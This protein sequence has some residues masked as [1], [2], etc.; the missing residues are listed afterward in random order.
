MEKMFSA[1]GYDFY[2]S[3]DGSFWNCVAEGAQAPR[4]SGGYGSVASLAKLKGVELRRL[5]S[6][7]RT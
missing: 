5:P 6:Q 1:K 2:R 4:P 7:F 3:R